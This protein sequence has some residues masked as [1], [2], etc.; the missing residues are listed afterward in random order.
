M[1]PQFGTRMLSVPQVQPL[2]TLILAYV[3]ALPAAAQIGV[4]Q[5]LE[6]PTAPPGRMAAPMVY[7]SDRDRL[8]MFGGRAGSNNLQETWEHDGVDWILRGNV[9]PWYSGNAMRFAEAVYDP[10][11]QVTL[12]AVMGITVMDTRQWDGTSWQALSPTNAPPSRTHFALAYDSARDRAVLVAGRQGSMSLSDTWEW[13]GTDWLLRTT[14]GPPPREAHAMAYDAANGVVVLFGGT[15]VTSGQTFAD[16]WMWNG[17]YWLQSFAP[18]PSARR[19]HHMAYDALRQ[20]VVL[21]GG[22]VVSA[23]QAESRQTWEWDGTAW[24]N[25]Q[26]SL[27]PAYEPS[28]TYDSLRQRVV[29]YGGDDWNSNDDLDE[30]WAYTSGVLASSVPYGTGCPGPSGV[31]LLHALTDAHLNQT[32]W[33]QLHNLPLPASHLA[34]GWL[35]FDNTQWAGLPLPL[36]LDP[37]GFPGCYAWVSPEQAFVM[38]KFGSVANLAIQIPFLPAFVGSHFYLQGGVL[39]PG[40]N[41]GGLVFSNAIDAVVGV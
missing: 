8:V 19:N 28:L 34:F 35:G 4:W 41:A 23:N 26:T 13:D 3:T 16:T 29:L 33:V 6:Y 37:A 5:E 39:V 17:T 40:F 30:T 22:L 11:R 9:G 25:M 36:A 1:E 31:P 14:G 2:K 20:R 21:H 27:P 12:V 24:H 32:M 15:S 18:G 7:D 10:V 38:Q